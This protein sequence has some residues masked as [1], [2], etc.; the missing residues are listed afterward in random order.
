MDIGISTLIYSNFCNCGRDSDLFT[1]LEKLSKMGYKY[2]EYSDQSVP[3]LF[4]LENSEI[5]KIL[6]HVS[7]LDL[8]IQSIHIPCT[9]LPNADIG[10]IDRKLREKSME[11][12]KRSLDACQSLKVKYAVIHPGGHRENFADIGILNQVKENYFE[13]LR[14]I[15]DYLQ[16]SDV[17]L[18]IENG[19]SELSTIKAI[20][21]TINL[22]NK[23]KIEICIDT[24]HANGA[25]K[26]NVFLI[27]D[28]G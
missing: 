10:S 16:K 13:S 7:C 15:C 6:Q 28:G 20:I 14:I 24:G 2:I 17:K 12:V 19:G 4:S 26:S 1:A 23:D 22:V 11:I 18:V 25:G 8:E 27:F 3:H 21:E 5:R 9:Q